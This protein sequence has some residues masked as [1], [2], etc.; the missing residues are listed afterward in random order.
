M[1]EAAMDSIA[2][3]I[4]YLFL[5]FLVTGLVAN[6]IDS[7]DKK[8]PQETLF[9]NEDSYV[10]KDDARI[11]RFN[12]SKPT[13]IKM[14]LE[15]KNEAP[16]DVMT[17]AGEISKNEYAVAIGAKVVADFISLFSTDAAKNNPEFF[18]NPLSH[19]GVFREFS[20]PWIEVEP[21]TYSIVVDNTDAFTPTRGDAPI[22]LKL[23]ERPLA[24]G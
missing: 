12:A 5:I 8:E 13:Q 23:Y 17:K 24:E 20:S 18:D 2:K 1:R 15:I 10:A 16:L 9:L 3:F 4:G 22:N 14:V 11:F 21:G 19:Q 6:W 7:N